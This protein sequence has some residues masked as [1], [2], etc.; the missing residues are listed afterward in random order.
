MVTGVGERLSLPVVTTKKRLCYNLSRCGLLM[1]HACVDRSN[2]V[3]M[4]C[5]AGNIKGLI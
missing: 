4:V 5:R 2:F 1:H 3:S